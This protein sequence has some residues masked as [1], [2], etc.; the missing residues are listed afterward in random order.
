[1]THNGSKLTD[2]AFISTKRLTGYFHKKASIGKLRVYK[3]V[4]YRIHLCDGIYRVPF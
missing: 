2:D 1:M 3:T 4:I